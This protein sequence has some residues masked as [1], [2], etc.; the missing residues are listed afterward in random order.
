MYRS[1]YRSK[2]VQYTYTS[3]T[4]DKLNSPTPCLKGR[5]LFRWWWWHPAL[6]VKTAEAACPRREGSQ[7]RAAPW[8]GAWGQHSYRSSYNPWSA[9]CWRGI[10]EA[11]PAAHAECTHGGTC[12]PLGCLR[13]GPRDAVLYQTYRQQHSPASG[14]TSPEMKATCVRCVQQRLNQ[15]H[16]TSSAQQQGGLTAAACP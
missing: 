10:A 3:F 2:P 8:P 16:T 13:G 15:V 12:S 6:S 14:L 11:A 4:F 1:M 5:H 9:G 7:W